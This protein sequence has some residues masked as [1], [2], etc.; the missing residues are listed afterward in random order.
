LPQ[1]QAVTL[2]ICLAIDDLQI[3]SRTTLGKTAAQWK[4]EDEVDEI[5]TVGDF[6]VCKRSLRLEQITIEML[7]DVVFAAHASLRN[8]DNVASESHCETYWP[9]KDRRIYALILLTCLGH[10]ERMLLVLA[11]WR[12]ENFEIVHIRF[13]EEILIAAPVPH[14]R[15]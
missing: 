15:Q 1:S 2:S 11:A 5:L 8:R 12:R 14:L 3:F 13:G 4:R 9:I 6:C 10:I 7:M